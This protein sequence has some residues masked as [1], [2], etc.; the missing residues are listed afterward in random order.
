MR[1]KEKKK[2][3]KL[4]TLF[5]VIFLF[6]IYRMVKF[7]IFDAEKLTTMA[8]SQYAYEEDTKDNKYK[9]LDTKGNDLLKY[10]EKYYAVLVPSA[11]KD[12]KEEKDEE[13]LLTIMYILRNYNEKYDIT[14]NQTIDNSGKNYYEIDKITYEK[15]KDIKGVKGF[16]TY[17]K[18][19]VDKNIND[20][21]EAWKLENML[22]NPY[23]N[24]QKT[25]KDKESL[26]MRI[27]NRVKDNKTSKIIY[28][29]DLQGEIISKETEEP[30]SN[31]NPKLTLDSKVQDS[32]RKILNKK[33][34]KAFNQVGVILSE[35][36]S[37]K[38]RAMVQKDETLPNINIGA[39]TQNGF[40]PGSIFKIITEEAALENNKVSLKD[41][42]KCT[43]EFESNKKGTHGSFS[44]KEAF[45]VSCNDIF[46]QIGRKAG[47]ENIDN[48]V[49]KHGLYSKVL[50]LHYEQ[51]GAIQTEKGEKPNLSDG[52]LSLVSFGQLIRIT[53]IE[54]VSMVS[55]VVNN[56]VYVKPYVL[57][58]FV[59]D[60]NNTIEEFN[61]TKE[62]II[63]TY[64]ANSLKEQ[65]KE[66][67]KRGT[68]ALAYDSSI[69]IGGKTGTNERQEVNDKG[70]MEHLSDAWFVGF[71]K[72][73]NKYYT[74]V[75]FI[76]KIK[77]KGESAGTTSVPIFYDIVKEIKD[78][79]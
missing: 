56:G 28:K 20:K 68:A 40:P 18:Q 8:E 42:F 63:G 39:A 16:Y 25:F 30:K 14:K 31:I 19:E 10:K 71:F 35:S 22:L 70:K 34:Y 54:A 37:G 57:E 44:T 5:M 69:E 53:P 72:S 1:Y 21:K 58:S 33:E 77:T 36:E 43:G 32:I 46:S 78:S 15:L 79:I 66:V 3:Y 52:T 24:D 64:S 7:Q 41:S 2:A 60:K 51:Q 29:K 26:E 38:I 45:I 59:D 55:T 23:K 73:N 6:L 17:K 75:V 48:M 12:N 47:F 9:L 50:D 13:K 74:M 61:T 11:F 49:K 65:M 67:V 27:Y 62:Q 76:P 4:L